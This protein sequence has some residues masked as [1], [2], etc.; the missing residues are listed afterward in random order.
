MPPEPPPSPPTAPAAP[1]APSAQEPTRR[2]ITGAALGASAIALTSLSGLLSGTVAAQ[3]GAGTR[4][5]AAVSSR[6]LAAIRRGQPRVEYALRERGLTLGAPLYLRVRKR[7]GVLETWLEEQR[8]GRYR[9]GRSY[10]LCGAAISELGPRTGA[11]DRRIPEGF[12]R[13]T[14]A[15]LDVR[16]T[17]ALASGLDWPNGA[18]RARGASGGPVRLTGGCGGGPDLTLT[19]TDFDELFTLVYAALAFGQPSV[20]VHIFP[21][22]LGPLERLALPDNANGAFWRTLAPAWQT[23]GRTGRPP[24]IRVRRGRYEVAE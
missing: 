5:R 11:A 10:R 14:P 8:G 12:Y 15:T 20:P 17:Q 6:G 16:G 4:V 9:A 19:D 1:A 7:E 18:D 2:D 24:S 21:H 3:G 13:V 22:A 23:F